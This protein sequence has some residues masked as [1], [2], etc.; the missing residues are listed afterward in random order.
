MSRK[1]T[2]QFLARL[3]RGAYRR[4]PERV[5]RSVKNVISQSLPAS[6]VSQKQNSLPKKPAAKPSKIHMLPQDIGST[7]DE[8]IILPMLA[9]ENNAL[10]DLLRQT[11]RNLEVS[12]RRLA[13]ATGS[14]LVTPDTRRRDNA[15]YLAE[16]YLAGQQ[17]DAPIRHLLLANEYPRQ[18]REYGN[19]FVHQRVKRYLE[20]GVAV[21]VV[22]AGYS[23]DQD[24]YE[25][26]GVRVLTG[27]GEEISETLK[28]QSYT[29]VSVHFLNRRIWDALEPFLENLDVHVFLHGYESSRWVRQLSNYRTGRDLERAI[30][31]SITLQQFWHEVLHHPHQPKSYIF[32]S[33]WW[34]RAVYDDTRVTFPSDRVHIIHN[35]INTDLFEYRPK[36]DEQRFNILWVRS[37]SNRKYG[38]DIAIR[39]LEQLSHSEHWERCKVTIIGD[40]HYFP[41]FERRLG[42]FNNVHIEQGF[43]SQEE[44]A[45]LHKTH[46]IFLVPSRLDSQGVSR[47][48][49]M[50]SG[51]VPVTNLVTAIPEFVDSNSGIVAE[52]EKAGPL[53]AGIVE[54]WE[55]PEKF[56]QLS[57]AAAQRVRNQSGREATIGRELSTLGLKG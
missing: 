52:A 2:D 34:R 53:A 36:A 30:E 33:D 38:N 42:K 18:G 5:R 48:E 26:D 31:R 28:R 8:N 51:L 3:A 27:H 40:G 57:R 37:A 23:V 44:I 35:Y 32:V 24:L 55:D 1:K 7:Y 22:C 20:V 14:P 41:E 47:D 19:G 25:Y 15:S 49:A 12:R 21:D 17:N 13:E 45:A 50:S 43:I 56:Q 11:K 16:R 4:A 9:L 39:V 54:L 6:A 10:H 29:S 46:G